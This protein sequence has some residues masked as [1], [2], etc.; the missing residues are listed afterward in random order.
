MCAR[1]TT[2]TPEVWA[3]AFDNWLSVPMVTAHPRPFV[4]HENKRRIYRVQWTPPLS[5]ICTFPYIC[6]RPHISH[7]WTY[8]DGLK[9]WLWVVEHMLQIIYTQLLSPSVTIHNIRRYVFVCKSLA[10]RVSKTCHLAHMHKNITSY[11][12]YPDAIYDIWQ[13]SLGYDIM[14]IT[15]AVCCQLQFTVH[16]FT[17][18]VT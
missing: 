2:H 1:S 8:I 7:F 10:T 4:C 18:I 3:I 14:I 11:L 9:F 13:P 6:R 17:F 12:C 15:L 16:P 5:L